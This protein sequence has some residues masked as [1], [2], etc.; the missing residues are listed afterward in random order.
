MVL[1]QSGRSRVIV[2]G[3]CGLNWI[4]EV[5]E[6]GRSYIK[7]DGS[8]DVKQDGLSKW[9]IFESKSGF[10]DS[11]NCTFQRDETGRS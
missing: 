4:I 9:T 8:K 5:T 6:S 11:K 7:L 3:P 10:P 1:S 2:D